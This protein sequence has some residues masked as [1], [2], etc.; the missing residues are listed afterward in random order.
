M[1]RGLGGRCARRS[2]FRGQELPDDR[3]LVV[4]RGF[5]GGSE[6]ID[7]DGRGNDRDCGRNGEDDARV[8]PVAILLGRLQRVA[9]LVRVVVFGLVAVVVVGVFGVV[10]VVVVVRPEVAVVVNDLLAAAD[11]VVLGVD[12]HE[13]VEH[14]GGDKRR[15]GPL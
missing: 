13:Q 6:R 1:G 15:H 4:E 8:R 5:Y 11:M 14:C 10:V 3:A 2:G 12:P 9:V 7:G